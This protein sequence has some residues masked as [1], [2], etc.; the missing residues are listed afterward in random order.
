MFLNVPLRDVV[1]YLSLKIK[2]ARHLIS[3]V[4]LTTILLDNKTGLEIVQTF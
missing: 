3:D 1:H 2:I 4:A